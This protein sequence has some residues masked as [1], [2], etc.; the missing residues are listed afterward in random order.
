MSSASSNSALS[1]LLVTSACV[2]RQYVA[3]AATGVVTFCAQV[4]SRV[5][6]HRKRAFAASFRL[7]PNEISTCLSI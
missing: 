5:A 7:A 4:V 1:L 3:D 6:L 2:V